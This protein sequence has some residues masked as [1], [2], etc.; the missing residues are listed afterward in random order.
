MPDPF[1]PRERK[2]IM[3]SWAQARAV[4]LAERAEREMEKRGMI[5]GAPSICKNCRFMRFSEYYTMDFCNHAGGPDRYGYTGFVEE[6]E[7]PP[8]WCPRRNGIW[9]PMIAIPR[10]WTPSVVMNKLGVKS[11]LPQEAP[12]KPIYQERHGSRPAPPEAPGQEQVAG[13]KPP[14]P[15]PVP[16][17][18]EAAPEAATPEEVEVE[19]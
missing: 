1:K 18:P 10:G 9:E 4:L 5:K 11:P 7:P 13:V 14:T 17:K 8:D 16:A 12:P 3:K 15:P 2:K 6:F 19:V